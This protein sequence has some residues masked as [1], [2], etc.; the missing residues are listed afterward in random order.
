MYLHE[1]NYQ[2]T[3]SSLK[4]LAIFH[5]LITDGLTC[6]DKAIY[7]E[8]WHLIIPSVKSCQYVSACQKLTKYFK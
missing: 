6:L 7:T 5:K 2:N 4:V 8:S 1:K 3:P